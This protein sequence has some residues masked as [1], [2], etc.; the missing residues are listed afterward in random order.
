MT[1]SATNDRVIIDRRP[2]LV[3]S[4]M[5]ASFDFTITPKSQIHIVFD[6][7]ILPA[8]TA[9]S[10][11]SNTN[12]NAPKHLHHTMTVPTSEHPAIDCQ[13]LTYAFSEGLESALEN[14]DLKLER[15]DR[16][17]LVGANGGELFGQ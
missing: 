10:R 15:G 1:K 5:C 13:G 11:I 17:L 9:I 16:A 3:V 6:Q 7:D 8:G 12:T 2:F 4:F 14:V